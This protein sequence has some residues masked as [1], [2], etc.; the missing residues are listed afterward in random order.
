MTLLCRREPMASSS[1]VPRG[2]SEEGATGGLRW[3]DTF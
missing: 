2:G 1:E 3:K